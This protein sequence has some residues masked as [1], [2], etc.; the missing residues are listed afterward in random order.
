MLNSKALRTL[1]EIAR[2]FALKTAVELLAQ[3]RQDVLGRELQS[4]MFEQ[5]RVE[6]LQRLAVPEQDIGG[7]LG[8]IRDP[9]VG[10]AFE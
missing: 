6:L 5:T 2:Q 9:G 8:L 7:E 4:G 3:E 10:A 1:L